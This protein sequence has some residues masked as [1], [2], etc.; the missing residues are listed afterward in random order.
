MF[1]SF[2]VVLSRISKLTNDLNFAHLSIKFYV[3]ILCFSN[4]TNFQLLKS[5][6]SFSKNL[7]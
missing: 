2:R 1:T 7:V 5:I 4:V 3:L 6:A